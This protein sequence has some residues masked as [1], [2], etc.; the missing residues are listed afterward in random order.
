MLL[1]FLEPKSG[2]DEHRAKSS[3]SASMTMAFAMMAQ[4]H[5]YVCLPLRVTLRSFEW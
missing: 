3:S 2:T 5:R 4:G 1:F